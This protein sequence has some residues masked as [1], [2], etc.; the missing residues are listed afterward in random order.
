[1]ALSG[2]QITRIGVGGGGRAYAPFLAKTEATVDPQVR[3]GSKKK[4]LEREE[5][6]KLERELAK[7]LKEAFK[8]EQ[9]IKK[10]VQEIEEIKAEVKAR[11]EFLK[12]PELLKVIPNSLA[13][14]VE[15]IKVKKPVKKAVERLEKLV[16]DKPLTPLQA[17]QVKFDLQTEEIKELKASLEAKERPIEV[18][19]EFVEVDDILAILI[20]LME[21]K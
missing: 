6:R 1:M 19:K 5:I 18:V 4:R 8:L 10:I 14:P 15:P 7:Q 21:I 2:N 20:S 16:V 11:P 17:L 9:P 3:G 12:L 13:K